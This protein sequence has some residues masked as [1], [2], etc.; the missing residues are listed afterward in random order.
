MSFIYFKSAKNGTLV[1]MDAET[2][3]DVSQSNTVTSNSVMS[4]REVGD[5]LIRGNKV[6]SVT[7]IVSYSKTSSQEGNPTPSEWVDLIEA[8]IDS[9]QRFTLY[10]VK[11]QAGKDILKDY[12]NLV[13]ADYGFVVD[14]FEDSITARITFQEIFVSNPATKTFLPPLRSAA[15]ASSTSNATKGGKGTAT[16]QSETLFVNTLRGLGVTENLAGESITQE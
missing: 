16:T 14:R 6:I 5:D 12:D 15:T 9:K 13:V 2:S 7:G 4:K 1:C 10:S 3:I 11:N 8:A